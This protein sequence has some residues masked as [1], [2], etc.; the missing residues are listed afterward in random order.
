MKQHNRKVLFLRNVY[1]YNLSGRFK[2]YTN[3]EKQKEK[4]LLETDKNLQKLLQKSLK[5]IYLDDFLNEKSKH[6]YEIDF[7]LSKG[8]KLYPIEVKSSGYN[9]HASLDAF[10]KKY[11]HIIENRYLIYTKDLKKD[12]DRA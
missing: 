1:N 11:S 4:Q 9:S 7:L 10:C 2:V 5:E 3:L 6:N 8:S 12:S